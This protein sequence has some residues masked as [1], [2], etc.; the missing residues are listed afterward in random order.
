MNIV[1]L[2]LRLL[3]GLIMLVYGLADLGDKPIIQALSVE[4][5][6]IAI[7]ETYPMELSLTITGQFPCANRRPVR[8]EQQ[9]NHTEN[10]ID[11]QIFREE[12]GGGC[13]TMTMPY[14]DTIHIEDSFTVGVYTLTVNNYTMTIDF[15]SGSS[16]SPYYP[17]RIGAK[18]AA[19]IVA[20]P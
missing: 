4:T 7:L 14:S 15:G 2:L 17:L 12:Y 13:L 5:V 16:T 10:T 9:V 8:V 3:V 18:T 1:E 19:E 6:E 11:V 20:V